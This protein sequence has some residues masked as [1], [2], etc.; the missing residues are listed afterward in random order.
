MKGLE[1]AE[2]LYR[3]TVRERIAEEF[4]AQESRIAVGL[5]LIHI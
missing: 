2:Q 4:P 5:S 1:L 3:E